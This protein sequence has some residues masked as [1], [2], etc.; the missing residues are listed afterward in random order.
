M[1][2][3]RNLD[4]LIKIS[5]DQ[6]VLPGSSSSPLWMRDTLQHQDAVI[7]VLAGF[8][9]LKIVSHVFGEYY[10]MSTGSR[11]SYR[12]YV[13]GDY[14]SDLAGESAVKNRMYVEKTGSVARIQASLPWCPSM[15]GDDRNSA[16]QH[17]RWPMRLGFI[18]P[19]PIRC[20]HHRPGNERPTCLVTR[21]FFQMSTYSA[22]LVLQC[23]TVTAQYKLWPQSLKQTRWLGSGNA[24]CN[25]FYSA[26]LQ[27]PLQRHWGPVEDEECRCSIAGHDRTRNPGTHSQG[28]LYGWT[29]TDARPHLVKGLVAIEPTGPPFEEAVFADT[30][31]RAWG[32]TDNPIHYEPAVLSPDRIK[33]LKLIS[34]DTNLVGCISRWNLLALCPTWRTFP[35]WSKC[36][37]HPT[38]VYDHCSLHFLR[39]A[40]GKAD[41]LLLDD[42][43]IKGIGHLQMMNNVE[44]VKVMHEWMQKTVGRR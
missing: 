13:E 27:I 40:D 33:M 36:L 28:G 16:A 44:V 3:P 31:A 5:L 20:L 7:W 1:L 9:C 10:L 41:L 26:T 21:R 30:P 19:R 6:L 37:S 39:Q 2:L 43:G 8:P 42:I 34:N 24:V 14:V 18:L 25:A 38:T 22:E 29:I 11:P 35:S 4:K 17:P 12:D 23:F 15:E 32:S